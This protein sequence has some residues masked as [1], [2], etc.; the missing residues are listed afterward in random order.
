MARNFLP[1]SLGLEQSPSAN[2]GKVTSK[3]VD[4][5]FRFEKTFGVTIRI[6][7]EPSIRIGQGKIRQSV[8]IDNALEVL[9]R[10]GDF[11]YVKDEQS[12]TITIR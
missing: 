9:R 10:F 4:G 8:G 7:R 6:E 12:N 3:G 1:Y 11:E 5:H 2:V